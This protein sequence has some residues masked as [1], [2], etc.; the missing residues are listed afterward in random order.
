M[1]EQ[2]E[3]NRAVVLRFNHKCL[4]NGDDSVLEHVLDSEFVNRTAMAGIDSGIEGMRYV[5]KD[6]LH[7][8]LS[9]VRVEIDDMIA[10]GDRVATRKR[11]LGRHTGEFLGAAPTGQSVEINVFDI[12]RLRGDKYLEHWGLNTIPLVVQSLKSGS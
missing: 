10:Q 6:V 9:E 1:D 12:V 8:G 4:A 5:I 11:I 3:K 7:K 2:L